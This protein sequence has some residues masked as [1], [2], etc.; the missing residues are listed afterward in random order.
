VADVVAVAEVRDA[1]PRERPEALADRHR[2]GERLQWMGCVGEAVDDGDRRVLRELVDLCLVE[3]ADHDAAQEA[4]ED[5]RGVARRL[6]ARELEVGGGDVERHAAQLRDPDLGADPRPCRRLA[7]DE[8]HGSPRE[9][10][11]LTA[12]RALDLQLVGEVE[13]C[14]ELVG[15][16]VRDKREAPSLERLGDP[17]HGAIVLPENLL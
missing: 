11:K 17:R 3:G 5:E 16:P 1:D 15:A 6:P 9:D 7:E 12:A 8:P 10:P 4:G 14:P 13:R 2:V